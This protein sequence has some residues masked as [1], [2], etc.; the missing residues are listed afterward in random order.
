MW[1][2]V[3]W[4]GVLSQGNKGPSGM[5]LADQKFAPEIRTKRCG[6]PLAFPANSATVNGVVKFSQIRA[7]NFQRP[8]IK[9]QKMTTIKLKAVEHQCVERL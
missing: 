2:G 9:I 1:I 7:N 6:F 5:R 4:N 3:D 8:I